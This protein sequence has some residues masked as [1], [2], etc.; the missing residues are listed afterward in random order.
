MTLG[1]LPVFA[2]VLVAVR[3]SAPSAAQFVSTALVALLAG[4]CATTLFLRARNASSDPYRIA[5]VDATQAGEVGFALLGEVALLGA[6][7]P[8]AAGWA[9]LAA[10]TAGLVGFVLASGPR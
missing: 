8:D 2:L 4:C 3:P 7:L 10:V 5:A 1:S 9:G 6:A